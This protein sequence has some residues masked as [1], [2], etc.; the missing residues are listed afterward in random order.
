MTNRTVLLC[1]AT[2]L[3]AASPTLAQTSKV[4][5][6]TSEFAAA[7]PLE[8]ALYQD[9]RYGAL[10]SDSLTDRDGTLRA[11]EYRDLYSFDGRAG[12]PIVVELSSPDFDPFLAVVSPS[13]RVVRND[14]GGEGSD[15][16][17]R[18]RLEE[19]GRYKVIVTSFLP[20]EQGSYVLKLTNRHIRIA[21]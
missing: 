13:G 2:A 18:I 14:D 3:V 5:P 12:D 17:I 6:T 10:T 4:L 11:G 9:M 7:D 16:L 8:E 20:R 21:Q 15:A 1:L 19:T